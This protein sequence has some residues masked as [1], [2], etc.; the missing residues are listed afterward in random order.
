[1]N[2]LFKNKYRIKSI[3]LQD[4]DYS[5]NGAYFI[6][7]C[8]K[9]RECV[10]GNIIDGKMELSK[11]GKIVCDEWVKTEQ[12]RKYIQLDEWIIMPNHFHGIVIIKNDNVMDNVET[13]R[14]V[15]LQ[16]FGT[17]ISKSLPIIVNHFKSAVKRWCN[18]NGYEQFQWQ[19]NYYEH[20][21]RNENELNRICE[22]IINN[23]LKWTL[24]RNNPDNFAL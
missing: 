13:R 22:Y 23:P 5:S 12:L 24:D 15:S 17:S 21:I 9:D 7:M 8:T 18:K 1:M 2:E 14:G 20:I 11:V 16:R 19:R 10:F 4:Y 3:R 6:T